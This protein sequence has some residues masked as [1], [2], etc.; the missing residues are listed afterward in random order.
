M[1]YLKGETLSRQKNILMK[2][3]FNER[4]L[5]TR[6]LLLQQVAKFSGVN[7]SLQTQKRNLNCR[8]ILS[9]LGQ[10]SSVVSNEASVDFGSKF[11][12]V[13]KTS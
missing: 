1:T 7:N 5:P 9:G 2:G 6:N 8:E 10:D 11:Q 12:K 4:H 3:M 13:N